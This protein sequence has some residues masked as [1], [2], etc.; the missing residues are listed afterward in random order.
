MDLRLADWAERSR[1]KTVAAIVA[2]NEIHPFR[3]FKLLQITPLTTCHRRRCISELVTSRRG[4]NNTARA[5]T[6]DVTRQRH[7][8][9]HILCIPGKNKTTQ[10]ICGEANGDNIAAPRLEQFRCKR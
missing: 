1:I 8:P 5:V 3:D 6:N 7:D 10:K 2:G 4:H 9:L